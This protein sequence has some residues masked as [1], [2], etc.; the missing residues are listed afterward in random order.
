MQFC[1]EIV[2]LFKLFVY[3][4][5]FIDVAYLMVKIHDNERREKNDL[6]EQNNT[7]KGIYIKLK[8]IQ[9]LTQD[10]IF[11]RYLF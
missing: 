2:E 1:N 4:S 3:L 6:K 9:S 5:A 10:K 11:D 7:L 8:H